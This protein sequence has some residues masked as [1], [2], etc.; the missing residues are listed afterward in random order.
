MND[1]LTINSFFD[2]TEI[3]VE[4]ADILRLKQKITDVNSKF[5]K[6]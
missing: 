3:L 1:L 6:E 4:N 2:P 5:I